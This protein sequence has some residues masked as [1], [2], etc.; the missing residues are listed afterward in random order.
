[1]TDPISDMIIR[2]QNAY[3][4]RKESVVIPFSKLKFE[5]ATALEKEGYIKGVAKKGKKVTKAIELGLVYE[6][7]KPLVQGVKRVSKPSRRVY[8]KAS[9]IRPV[10]N[11]YGSSFISTPKGILL[12]KD[13]KKE[14][15]GGEILFS[16]W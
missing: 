14:L 12:D 11:G 16:I 8:Q 10:K 7:G 3:R 2:I 9:E 1:M 13:A 5:I 4:A 15:V 6:G